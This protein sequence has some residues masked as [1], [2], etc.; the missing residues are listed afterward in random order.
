MAKEIDITKKIVA[1]MKGDFQN[2]VKTYEKIDLSLLSVIKEKEE[3]I[4]T[5]L[6]LIEDVP[7]IFI[8]EIQKRRKELVSEENA[9]SRFQPQ[10][11]SLQEITKDFQRHIRSIT[12]SGPPESISRGLTNLKQ[13][14]TNLVESIPSNEQEEENSIQV[15]F[16]GVIKDYLPFIADQVVESESSGERFDF[17]KSTLSFIDDLNPSGK[18]HLVSIDDFGFTFM[19]LSR[20][21]WNEWYALL[22]S[23]DKVTPRNPSLKQQVENLKVEFENVL[24]ILRDLLCMFDYVPIE[25][26]PGKTIFDTSCYETV[27]STNS[28][29]SDTDIPETEVIRE[30]T[31]IGFKNRAGE[32]METTKV[33]L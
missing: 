22:V 1:K 5:L 14:I 13:A 12:V 7:V 17:W 28:Q 26:E 9:F 16:Q 27:G 20:N 19:E 33:I 23:Y 29:Y 30:V 4:L 25:A 11:D 8:N 32:V 21:V 15:D 24:A 3:T 2:L 10:F 31:R 18:S 6:Q